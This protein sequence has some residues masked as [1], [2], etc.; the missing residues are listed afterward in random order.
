[1]QS[2][3]KRTRGLRLRG[4][5]WHIQKVIYGE[6]VHEST[7][8]GDI[9]EAE[10][11]LARR[12]EQI[13]N[14][15]VYGARTDHSLDEAAA[16]YLTDHKDERGIE[17]SAYALTRIVEWFGETP[18]A[19]INGETL[20]PYLDARSGGKLGRAVRPGTLI[21]E[22]AALKAVLR[23]AATIWRNEN[24]TTWL[25]RIPDIP[26][27]RNAPRCPRPIDWDEQSRLLQALPDYLATLALFAVNTGCRDQ[28]AC[29][30]RWEWEHELH[31]RSAFVIPGHATKNGESKIVPLNSIAQSIVD[32]ERGKSDEWVF[33][34]RGDRISRMNNRAWRLARVEAG[35]PDV[36]VHDLRHAFAVRL[37]AADVA[38]EDI[39]DLLG[40][41]KQTVTQHYA[42][43]TVD[44]LFSCVDKLTATTTR[45]A[46]LL[47]RVRSAA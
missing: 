38:H 45:P 6:P 44:R 29:G 37:R 8:T 41:K 7:H 47:R 27:I 19:K 28:E 10:R 4:G 11:Y 46:V 2:K 15:L 39:Q 32:T 42:T 35:L 9:V 40:H 14:T 30:L 21:R 26:S 23:C 3:K 20:R 17:R 12:T 33:T 25:E 31:G 36:R 22:M 1:M 34:L 43:A 24:G 18:V 5:I 13:R 16:R